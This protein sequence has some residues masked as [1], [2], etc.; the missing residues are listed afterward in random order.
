MRRLIALL[1]LLITVPAC[2]QPDSNPLRQAAA[3]GIKAAVA[4]NQALQR[5]ELRR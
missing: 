3:E 2:A 4:I 5:A 1:A